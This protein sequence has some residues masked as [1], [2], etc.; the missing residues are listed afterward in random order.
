MN[1]RDVRRM[2]LALPESTEEPHFHLTSFRVRRKIFATAPPDSDYLHVFVDEA[3]R[4]RYL[5]AEPDFLEPLTWGRKVVGLR[6]ILAAAKPRV[7]QTMLRDAWRAK[8]PKRLQQAA[9][10]ATQSRGSK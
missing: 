5:A 2:A 6:V 4:N 3:A 9:G 7:V 1:L 8:A 10:I